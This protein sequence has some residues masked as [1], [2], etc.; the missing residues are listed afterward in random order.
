MPSSGDCDRAIDGVYGVTVHELPAPESPV[1]DEGDMLNR[2]SVV[3]GA[4]VRDHQ[5]AS[6]GTLLARAEM[7]PRDGD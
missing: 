6:A 5:N 7:N 4:H 1:P 3:D 2:A